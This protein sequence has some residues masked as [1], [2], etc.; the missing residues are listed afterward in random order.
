MYQAEDVAPFI[1]ELK[2]NF[3]H[4]ENEYPGK[5]FIF[6][7][8]R[9]Y[10]SSWN[11]LYFDL[12][13]KGGINKTNTDVHVDKFFAAVKDKKLKELILFNLDCFKNYYGY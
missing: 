11:N 10:L 2:K 4:I 1:I 7:E 13:I 6:N 9:L 8:H 12:D 5:S 3:S